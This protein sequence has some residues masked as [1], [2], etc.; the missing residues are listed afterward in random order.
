MAKPGGIVLC[1]LAPHP[2]LLI[3]EI[4]ARDLGAV[5]KT[6]DAMRRMGV[7]VKEA[8]PDVVVVIS[9]HAPLFDDAIALLADNPLSGDFSSFMAPEVS[10]SFENDLDLAKKIADQAGALGVNALLLDSK[11]RKAYHVHKGLDH[12]VLVPMHFLVEA[13]VRAPLVAMGM[14]LLPR[15]RLYT[16]GQAI[17][18]AARQLGCRAVVVASGDL[19]HRLVRG[20]PAGYDPRGKEFDERIV[21]LLRAGDVEGVLSLDNSLVERAGECGYRSLLMA[22]GTLDGY[23]FEPEVLS[24]EGPF[25]V[26]YAVAVFRPQEA[27]AAGSKTVLERLRDRQR[28]KLKQVREGESPLVRL[29]RSAV[30]AYVR[31]GRVV[32]PPDELPQEMQGRA[33]VFCSIKKGGQLRGCIGTIQPTTA[34]IAREII[35]NAIAAA[36]EDP[37]FMPVEPDE[38]DDLVYSVDVLMPAERIAS[39]EELDPKVYGVIVRKGAR[40]GL[41][42]PDLEGIDDSYEQVAIAKRKAGIAPEEDVE[43]WRF[44]VKRYK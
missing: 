4:G 15:E 43:L 28:R 22:L 26:G 6:V 34:S 11:G 8:A 37:R 17:A 2:P 1:A 16:F 29:A 40:S 24:Y 36:T 5:E 35:R 3:P 13:G 23:G 19:S 32:D 27:V 44:E 39:I 41:L 20:A 7:M 25:G 33:G 9:P 14:A 21:E 18:R 10:Y 31:H 42:L 38:L 30:E 12:G